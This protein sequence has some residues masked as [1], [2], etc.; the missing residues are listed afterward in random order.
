MKKHIIVF[1]VSLIIFIVMNILI[2]N[3]FGG[4][5][6][7]L[8]V[9]FYASFMIALVALYF[10]INEHIKQ[11]V[12]DIPEGVEPLEYQKNNNLKSKESFFINYAGEFDYK[13]YF[14]WKF[15]IIL[16][17][18]SIPLYISYYYFKRYAV[19]QYQYLILIF[20]TILALQIIVK[21]LIELGVI[22]VKLM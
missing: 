2:N 9:L 6:P 19:I 4:I 3:I 17:A 11:N 10:I 1:N 7:L 8:T 16:S 14:T 18:L 13:I 21:A 22:K 5:N 15:S 20:A 12:F